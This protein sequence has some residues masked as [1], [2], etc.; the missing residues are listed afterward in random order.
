[1]IVKITDTK[2]FK[3]CIK[4]Q[5][6]TAAEGCYAWRFLDPNKYFPYEKLSQNSVGYCGL[7]GKPTV[8]SITQPKKK[9]G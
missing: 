2:M 4:H 7:G 5:Q 6:C 8:F 9:G 1:M 3:C